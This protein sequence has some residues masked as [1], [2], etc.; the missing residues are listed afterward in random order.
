M[1]NSYRVMVD[2]EGKTTA[3]SVEFQTEQRFAQAWQSVLK[4]A[5]AKKVVR[6]TCPG[7]GEKWLSVRY[8]EESDS[9]GLAKYPLTGAEHASECKFYAPNPAM[10][11][12]SGYQKGVIDEGTDGTSKIRLAIGLRKRTAMAPSENVTVHPSGRSRAKQPAMRLLGLLNY[13]WD[14]AKL[15]AWW[16]AMIGKRNIAVVNRR[17]S[18]VAAHTTAAGIRLNKVLLLTAKSTTGEWAEH[19]RQIVSNALSSNYRLLVIAPL[20][21]YN[22]A[23]EET[24]HSVLHIA[25]F[26]GIPMLDMAAGIWERAASRFP[27]ALGAWRQG[28]AIVVIA[29]IELKKGGRYANVVDLALMSVTENWIPFDSM[30]ELKVANKLSA[31]GRAFVKPLRFDADADVVFPD[32]I[33]RDTGANTPLEVFGCSDESYLAR[34]AAK[35]H[36]YRE[37]FGIDGWWCWNAAIDPEGVTMMPFPAAVVPADGNH[38]RN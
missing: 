29:E 28:A 19:N 5:Y 26:N 21:A 23:K 30:F 34:K 4:K 25:G 11:G 31:E 22:E 14:E 32:F 10:S 13:L 27:R 24:L 8:Y 16:P 15:N 1:N 38:E 35:D 20:A 12:M 33:L 36:Y 6:C 18:T 17:L 37:H 3:Y 7:S 9:F 2:L